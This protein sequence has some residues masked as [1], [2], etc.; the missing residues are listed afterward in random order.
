MFYQMALMSSISLPLQRQK[1]FER[2]EKASSHRLTKLRYREILFPK[3]QNFSKAEFD[4]VSWLLDSKLHCV[5]CSANDRA[6][7]RYF[8]TA[9]H[10]I[11]D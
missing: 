10:A 2:P 9:S 1:E 6:E 3:L 8:K 5:A 7:E 11:C 4:S